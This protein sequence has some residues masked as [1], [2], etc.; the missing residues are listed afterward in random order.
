MSTQYE[1]TYVDPHSLQFREDNRNQHTPEQIDR[2][3][4]IIQ[5]NG[6]RVPVI[7]SSRSQKVV[8]GHGRLMAAKKLRLEKVPVI[9]QQFESEDE[10]FQFHIADNAI[11]AWAELD[12]SGINADLEKYGPFEIDLLGIKD[13]VLEPAEKVGQCDEDEIPEIGESFVKEGDIWILGEHRL[14]C[15]DSTSIDAVEKLMNGEKADMVFTD[16]PYGMNLDTDYSSMG[17]DNSKYSAEKGLAG[18]RGIKHKAVIGDDKDFD[19]GIVFG[20]FD[21]CSE[22]FLWGADYYAERLLNKNNGSWIVWDKRV[23]DNFDKMWG[24]SFELCWSKAKHKR[25]IARIRFAGVYGT[26]SQDTHGRV[27]PTQKP[28]QLAE[29]FFEKWGGDCKIVVDLYGGSG[30]TLIACEKTNRKCFMSEIDPH[31]CG[32]IIER[33]QKF[34]GKKATR[35]SS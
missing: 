35:V 16:P 1:I 17:G 4:Q 26:E 34:T 29:W 31:Y 19:P 18:K 13:F 11:A 24:S 22:I 9:Y 33:W 25:D 28:V 21:Y 2:L 6:F 10:E 15:G 32:V 14:M 20:L 12:L 23:D 8:A 30:S 7:V 3:A 27:H 5:H